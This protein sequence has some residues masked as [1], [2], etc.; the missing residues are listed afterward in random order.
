[1]A[2]HGTRNRESVS[3]D[4]A[5][6]L[7]V[8]GNVA[9]DHTGLPLLRCYWYEA[10]VEGRRS[11]EH[12]IL[13]G[14]PGREAAARQDEA[15][16]PRGRRRRDPPRPD[17]ARQEPGDQRCAGGQRGGR[18]RAGDRRR[19]GPRPARDPGAHRRARLDG[20]HRAPPGV[21]RNRRDQRGASAAFGGA[22]RRGRAGQRGRAPGGPRLREPRARQR[23][24]HP[25][26]DGAASAARGLAR[27]SAR[28]LHR[29]CDRPVPAGRAAREQPPAAA[30]RRA[31]PGSGR[32]PQPGAAAGDGAAGCGGPARHGTGRHAEARA[33]SPS[34]RACRQRSR[35]RRARGQR[36]SRPPRQ[37]PPRRPHWPALRRC[38]ART[39]RRATTPPRQGTMRHLATMSPGRRST[40]R[41]ASR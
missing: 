14:L 33:T 7:Q 16:P 29:V 18:P 5:G 36:P 10:T 35:P 39:L 38:P 27:R 34:S 22:C 15:R 8:L 30:G 37:C 3:W 11:S 20:C 19:A 28:A 32:K 12:E 40:R 4:Y 24:R 31:R 25:R 21:R 41:R 1:M 9:R 13:A 26:G 2:V 6:V 23:P 17:H